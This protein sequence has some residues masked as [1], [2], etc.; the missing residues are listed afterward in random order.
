M[1]VH[2]FA[3]GERFGGKMGVLDR[4]RYSCPWSVVTFLLLFCFPLE[5]PGG[6]TGRHNL[7]ITMRIVDAVFSYIPAHPH[8]QACFHIP[9]HLV[10]QLVLCKTQT[11]RL[12][13]S[14]PGNTLSFNVF[15]GPRIESMNS[16]SL[17]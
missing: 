5:A 10:E 2:S 15:G 17:L 3:S 14:C 6:L 16:T 13:S 8:E 12:W 1:G 7:D 9:A 11:V 4:L